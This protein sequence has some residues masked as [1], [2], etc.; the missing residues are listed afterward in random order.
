[1]LDTNCAYPSRS[2][3]KQRQKTSTES[4]SL[5]MRR[6]KSP[7]VSRGVPGTRE[8]ASSRRPMTASTSVPMPKCCVVLGTSAG[9]EGWRAA[10]IGGPKGAPGRSEPRG[11][12][13]APGESDLR[14]GQAGASDPRGGQGAT[15]ASEPRPNG[16]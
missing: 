9:A 4:C 2:G 10:G 13:G 1:M 11:A 12:K 15:G 8:E 3:T 16:G 7:V 6:A 5:V 14:G